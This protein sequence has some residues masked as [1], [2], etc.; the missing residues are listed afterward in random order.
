MPQIP[1]RCSEGCFIL[2]LSRLGFGASCQGSLVNPPAFL[3]NI[4]IIKTGGTETVSS[5]NIEKEPS[6]NRLGGNR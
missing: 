5:K 3:N 4:N 1:A 6:K 2:I